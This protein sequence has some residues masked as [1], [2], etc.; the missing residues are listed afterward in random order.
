MGIL[1][2]H[3]FSLLG[4]I[5]LT[6]APGTTSEAYRFQSK[7]MYYLHKD[8]EFYEIVPNDDYGCYYE[9]SAF[10]NTYVVTKASCLCR[11][12]Q[13]KEGSGF[14]ITKAIP[15]RRLALNR[16]SLTPPKA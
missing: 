8:G 4:M 12:I 15:S 10:S 14:L 13:L 6:E 5:I 2:S 3:E 11:N 16:R 1:F 9:L 7:T